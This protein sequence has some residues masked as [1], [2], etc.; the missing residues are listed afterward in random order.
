[1][2][3]ASSPLGVSAQTSP[4]LSAIR[5]DRNTNTFRD[6]L[7]NALVSD[8]IDETRPQN[9][10]NSFEPAFESAIDQFRDRLLAALRAPPMFRA[11][12]KGH[13]SSTVFEIA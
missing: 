2:V 3:S 4:F 1:M 8:R 6:S 10:I 7:N 11:S 5:L 9:D 12:C 13:R